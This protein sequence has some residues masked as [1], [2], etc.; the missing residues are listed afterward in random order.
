MLE[1]VGCKHVKDVDKPDFFH[2][3]EDAK[4]PSAEAFVLERIFLLTF[5]KLVEKRCL[6]KRRTRTE[7]R[8]C[9][10]I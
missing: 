5:G 9:L 2:F 8:I 7:R 1:N 4:K 3:L 6:P 10:A